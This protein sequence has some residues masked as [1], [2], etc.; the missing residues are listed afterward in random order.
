GGIAMAITRRPPWLLCSHCGGHGVPVVQRLGWQRLANRRQARL[1][2][3]QLAPGDVLFAA[4]AKLRPEPRD[5]RIELQLAFVDQLHGRHGR[6]GF[7]AGEQVD[8]GIAMP[9]LLAGVVSAARPQ[10][11]Y[12]LAANHHAYRSA[13]LPPLFEELLKA[14]P[15]RFETQIEI[16]LNLHAWSPLFSSQSHDETAAGH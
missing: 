9:G 13:S 2:T 4:G 14:L 8:Q 6:Q 1:M 12:C 7:G 16:A 15:E 3:E 10:I 5:R 11:D